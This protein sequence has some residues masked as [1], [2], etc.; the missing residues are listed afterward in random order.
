MQ[1]SYDN[2]ELLLKE[3]DDI[4]DYL[5][6]KDEFSHLENRSLIDKYRE[7]TR[8]GN[9][10]EKQKEINP[11][12]IVKLL[13]H[14]Q[15]IKI[16]TPKM[17]NFNVFLEQCELSE[18]YHCR[19]D[20][21]KRIK[22][23]ESYF[24]EQYH[25]QAVLKNG[26]EETIEGMRN[27]LHSFFVAY[28]ENDQ[29]V[30]PEVSFHA[31]LICSYLDLKSL[32]DLF[33]FH[34]DEKKECLDLKRIFYHSINCLQDYKF[35][36]NDF[37]LTKDEKLFISPFYDH[38]LKINLEDEYACFDYLVEEKPYYQNEPSDFVKYRIIYRYFKDENAKKEG[39]YLL[40]KKSN[41][42]Y[43]GGYRFNDGSYTFCCEFEDLS[44]VNKLIN[45]TEYFSK[46]KISVV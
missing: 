32:K 31:A 46:V 34:H 22:T 24:D 4:Q 1:I 15:K 6:L 36:E 12:D 38:L 14:K 41:D 7:L 9:S 3:L 11:E 44:D 27:A 2:Y 26:K 42:F 45:E 8:L 19:V 28:F 23:T 5:I 30:S 13:I 33:F 43:I 20:E 17:V 21:V 25:I 10:N 29:E 37:S 18:D 39:S 40:L 16:N 35:S